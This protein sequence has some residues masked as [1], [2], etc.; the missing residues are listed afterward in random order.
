MVLDIS[1]IDINVLRFI[2]DNLSSQI[3]DKIM[4]FITALGNG[5]LIWIIIGVILLF[6]N[7]YRKIGITMLVALLITSL[8]GEV[9]IKNIVKRPRPF[10][11]F[12]NIK[13]MI[14]EP[15]SYSFPSGHTASSFAAAVVLSHYIKK[16][17]YLFYSL[18]SLIAF[19]RLYLLVHYPSDVLG[20]I[21]LG[22]VCSLITIKIID[23]IKLERLS[24]E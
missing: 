16:W 18:A 11:T 24:N 13:I 19:S 22:V 17:K 6:S 8:F 14:K 9:I 2:S 4:S 23:N 5:G 3:M 10:I 21:I 12:P 20:G 1:S 15:L 7:K